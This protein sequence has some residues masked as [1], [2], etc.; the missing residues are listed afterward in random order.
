[1]GRL[2]EWKSVNVLAFINGI[3]N[4]LH[5]ENNLCNNKGGR[6]VLTHVLPVFSANCNSARKTES[7]PRQQQQQQQHQSPP[8]TMTSKYINKNRSMFIS[9]PVYLHDWVYMTQKSIRNSKQ[10][11]KKWKRFW[12]NASDIELNL[13]A[14][15]HVLSVPWIWWF[16]MQFWAYAIVFKSKSACFFWFFHRFI[17]LMWREMNQRIPF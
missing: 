12:W 15:W 11:R 6:N 14:I 13:N 5:S 16:R 7:R 9:A 2:V 1:M 10:H 3:S 17:E 4:H 8:A